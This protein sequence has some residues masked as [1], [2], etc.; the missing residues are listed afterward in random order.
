MPSFRWHPDISCHEWWPICR[1]KNF[2][3]LLV[4]Q[5]TKERYDDMQG[6]TSCGRHSHESSRCEHINILKIH[7]FHY[8]TWYGALDSEIAVHTTR[9][10]W[11]VIVR[12]LFWMHTAVDNSS[13]FSNVF[14]FSGCHGKDATQLVE[15]SESMDISIPGN[16][17]ASS[18]RQCSHC[19]VWWKMLGNGCAQ[20]KEHMQLGQGYV[21]YVLMHTSQARKCRSML[22][23]SCYTWACTPNFSLGP[24]DPL[25]FAGSFHRKR[26]MN[27]IVGVLFLVGSQNANSLWNTLGFS[28]VSF[29]PFWVGFVNNP[30]VHQ[31]YSWQLA[32]LRKYLVLTWT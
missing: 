24:E 30:N 21:W 23:R 15:P 17:A 14:V 12:N 19:L 4:R 8:E 13:S 20:N 22:A 11:K 25:Q 7:L 6:S 10:S 26:F 5:V 28:T 32:S 3:E 29:H 2:W 31:V 1:M 18:A 16:E 9:I 27:W